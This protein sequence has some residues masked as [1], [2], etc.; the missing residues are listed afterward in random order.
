MRM[1]LQHIQYILLSIL[2]GSTSRIDTQLWCFV[3]QLYWLWS[4]L[5]AETEYI[6]QLAIV[7]CRFT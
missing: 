2:K 4:S 1:Q 3:S 7:E 5:T 6:L